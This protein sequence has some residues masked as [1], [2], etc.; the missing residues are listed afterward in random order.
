MPLASKEI[1]VIRSPSFGHNSCL[2]C[3]NGSCEPTL[4]IYFPRAFQWYKEIFNPMGFDPWKN[5]LKIR[6]SNSQNESSLG[7]VSV[8]SLT[9]SYTPGSIRCDS[10]ASFLSRTLI[11]LCLGRKPK[12]K[13]VTSLITRGDKWELF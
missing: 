6:E 13:V 2:K 5:S 4:D 10:W 7:S 1:E 3:P 8:H 9:L 11:S 12:A